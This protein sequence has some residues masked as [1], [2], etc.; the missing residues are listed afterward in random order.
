MKVLH[1]LAAGGT[2]GIETLVKDYG[3][4]SKCENIFVFPWNGGNLAEC[5]RMANLNVFEIHSG[6]TDL[7]KVWRALCYICENEHV[8]AVVEHHSAPFLLL[9]MTFLKKS[10]A[11]L[12]LLLMH[13]AM[14]R[15][16]AEEAATVF[17]H[18]AD[19]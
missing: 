1:V 3:E 16:C 11:K 14:Q 13:T 12:R 18:C 2:G 19:G 15:I 5:M 6:K 8:D 9:E 17:W 4:Y 10:I 7:Y